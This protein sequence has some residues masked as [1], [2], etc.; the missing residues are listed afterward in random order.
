MKKFRMISIFVALTF[1][2]STMAIAKTTPLPP[3]PDGNTINACYQKV[4]GMLRIVNTPS[5][6]RPSELPISWSMGIVTSP[7]SGV[8]PAITGSATNWVFAGPTVSV[9]TTADQQITGV[10]QATLGIVTGTA[11]FSY[12]LCYAAAATPTAL[13]NFAGTN[14]PDGTITAAQ[15]SFTA[16]GSVTPGAGTWIVGF[17]VLNSGANALDNNDIVNGWIITE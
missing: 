11:S 3:A 16:A 5:D 15:L 1:V 7:I 14:S 13:T 8:I 4:K 12:D 6:C 17:C 2:F 10:A 9:T